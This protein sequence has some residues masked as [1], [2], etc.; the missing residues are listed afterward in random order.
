MDESAREALDYALTL[1]GSLPGGKFGS[2][3]RAD[4][5]AGGG[6]SRFFARLEDGNRRVVVMIDR[7]GD[8]FDSYLSVGNF[9]REN[10][11]AVPDFYAA[12]PSMGV[13]LMEDLGPLHLDEVLEKAG[14]EEELSFY[15]ECTEMLLV[16]QTSVTAEMKRRGFL[17]SR[18]FD[19]ETLLSETDYFAREYTQRFCNVELPPQWEDER[20]KLAHRLSSLPPQFMHR[21]FQS[22]NII[23]KD[24]RLRI[25][26]F[27]TAHRGPGLYDTASLL[28]DP[29]HPILP[30]TRRTLLM[31]L[32]YR[33]RDSGTAVA[34]SFEEYYEDFIVAGIQRNLQALAAYS[35]LGLE[36]GKRE[37]LDSI[38]AGL[39]LVE[40]GVDESGNFPGIKKILEDIRAEMK[41]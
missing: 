12:D 22:R 33:L 5:L 15:R 8:E 37:F 32:Y 38:P 41:D 14:P 18:I 7:S 17:E 30:G 36:M 4:I 3:A 16:L 21:D 25:I 26:D 34:E 28:K 2:S 27:Q 24:G 35:R 31:E 20:R 19:E 6:S 23:V 9:L 40:E 10:E 13:L 1:T 39:D 29:Y 11:I